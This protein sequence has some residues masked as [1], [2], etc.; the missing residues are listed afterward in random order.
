MWIGFF[1]SPELLVAGEAIDSTLARNVVASPLHIGMAR[2]TSLVNSHCLISGL[3]SLIVAAIFVCLK[4]WNVRLG[5]SLPR[6]PTPA[7]SNVRYASSSD[8]I[9]RS[10]EMTR[11]AITGR[12]QPQQNNSL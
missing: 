7:P 8:G 10:S 12:E 3:R 5:S 1:A 11:G 9:L 6:Q 4:G 2:L